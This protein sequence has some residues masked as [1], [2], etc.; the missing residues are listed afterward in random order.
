MSPFH[1][2]PDLQSK[3]VSGA[4]G[5]ERLLSLERLRLFYG[6]R[7]NQPVWSD[8]GSLSPQVD[9]LVAALRTADREGLRPAEYHTEAIETLL[10]R[11]RAAGHDPATAADATAGL[12]LLLSDAFFLYGSHLTAGR[13][14]P[15]SVE[16][17]WN[18]PGRGR[19]LVFL[20]GAA[21]EHEHLAAT[22]ALLPPA[23]DDYRRLREELV[24]LRAIAAAGGWPLVPGEEALRKGDR[25]PRVAALRRRLAVTGELPADGTVVSAS[26]PRFTARNTASRRSLAS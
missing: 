12:D 3:L 21:L 20:L 7:G 16:P 11:L 9:A 8:G 13:V 23:R 4:A 22:L 26:S 2:L 10:R 17:E 14:N 15:E 18:L 19:D 6:P 1:A 25:G 24:T 5:G